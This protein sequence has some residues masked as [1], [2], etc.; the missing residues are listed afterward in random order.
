MG[1]PLNTVF[2]GLGG[3]RIVIFCILRS[4]LCILPLHQKLKPQHEDATSSPQG[5]P[6]Q[7][8]PS[9]A[10][11]LEM[12]FQLHTAQL[13]PRSAPSASAETLSATTCK[14]AGPGGVSA[15]FCVDWRC[16]PGPQACQ[17][18]LCDCRASLFSPSGPVCGE[19]R[20]CFPLPPKV[21]APKLRGP[22]FSTPPS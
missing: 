13:P 17:A 16:D 19:R 15:S 18:I 14:L 9:R 2:S 1:A 22:P 5:Y 21:S 8:L 6:L 7:H 3:S 11:E 12:P 20:P 4:F 10:F